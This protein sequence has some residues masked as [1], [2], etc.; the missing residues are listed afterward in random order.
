MT[1]SKPTTFGRRPY[2]YDAFGE[3]AGIKDRDEFDDAYIDAL[4]DLDKIMKG[5][6]YCFFAS[7]GY[8]ERVKKVSMQHYK[9]SVRSV[10]MFVQFLKKHVDDMG[11][12]YLT[13]QWM[14]EKKYSDTVE[15]EET[16]IEDIRYGEGVAD[17]EFKLGTIYHFTKK[18][19][20]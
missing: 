12:I 15:V 7:I 18:V 16:Y 11:E 1:V 14:G 9:E 4:S 8:Y 19:D 10:D 6:L 17:F 5:H 20:A 13:T 3:L 2:D